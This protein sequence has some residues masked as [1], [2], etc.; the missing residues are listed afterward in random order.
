MSATQEGQNAFFDGLKDTDNPYPVCTLVHYLWAAG[1]EFECDLAQQAV[2]DWA[3]EISG[4]LLD[5]PDGE[6]L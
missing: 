5:N 1:W 4:I 3:M 6:D 2:S